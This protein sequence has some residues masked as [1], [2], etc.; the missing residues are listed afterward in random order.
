LNRNFNV[1]WGLPGHNNNK[2]CEETYGGPSRA[3]EIEV[4]AIKTY[5]QQQ[6][7][8]ALFLD[9]HSFGQQVMSPFGYKSEEG[10]DY[11]AQLKIADLMATGAAVN[12]RTYET[13]TLQKV[14]YPVYGSAIDWAYEGRFNHLFSRLSII[15]CLAFPLSI[16]FPGEC[17]PTLCTGRRSTGRMR[18]SVRYCLLLFLSCVQGV[19]LGDRLGV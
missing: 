15:N 16:T 8:L 12:G 14:A 5:V 17:L 7:R 13:G 1:G 9:V 19:R 11:T 2:P 18:V 10:E 3:S 6:Q 4:I